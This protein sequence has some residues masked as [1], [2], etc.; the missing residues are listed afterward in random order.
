MYF[1][2]KSDFENEATYTRA[3]IVNVRELGRVK[4]LA[5]E[6]LAGILPRV[7]LRIDTP[8]TPA[9]YFN[10]GPMFIVSSKLR[11][12]LDK[13]NAKVEFHAVELVNREPG[14]N[15]QSYF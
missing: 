9:D 15:W 10:A 13:V 14:P 7:A 4:L 8:F 3:T 2:W 1:V 12:L 5:A 6:P 11:N